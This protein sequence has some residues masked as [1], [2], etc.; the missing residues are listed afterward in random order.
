[1]RSII[2]SM[3][4]PR[5]SIRVRGERVLNLTEC[6]SAGLD[7]Y[8]FYDIL[9]QGILACL[10]VH[11]GYHMFPYTLLEDHLDSRSRSRSSFADLRRSMAL[12]L[13]ADS[14]I[15]FEQEVLCLMECSK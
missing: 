5:V 13:S 3:R 9:I 14:E 8:I 7:L 6:S 15:L 10:A 11:P 2:A 12:D 1:L 4:S